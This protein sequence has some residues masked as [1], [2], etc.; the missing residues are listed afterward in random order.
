MPLEAVL[1][2]IM[3]V[4]TAGH[5]ASPEHSGMKPQVVTEC[6][7]EAK[8]TFDYTREAEELTGAIEDCYDDSEGD[9]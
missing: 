4:A 6:I 7:A 5:L 2:I 9:D 8:V 3:G 1:V